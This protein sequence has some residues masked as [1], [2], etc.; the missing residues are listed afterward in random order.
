MS[1]R[2]VGTVVRHYK[3]DNLNRF[4][5]AEILKLLLEILIRNSVSFCLVCSHI[6]L[7]TYREKSDPGWRL[8]TQNCLSV[9]V[10]LAQFLLQVFLFLPICHVDNKLRDVRQQWEIR[11]T[12]TAGVFT[13]SKFILSSIRIRTSKSWGVPTLNRSRCVFSQMWLTV[14]SPVTSSHNMSDHSCAVSCAASVS[15]ANLILQHSPPSLTA[16]WAI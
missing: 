13:L 6:V 12:D 1:S 9:S 8:D 10:L 16:I 4:H 5:W 11:Q 7:T 3:S 14:S 2:I 15:C